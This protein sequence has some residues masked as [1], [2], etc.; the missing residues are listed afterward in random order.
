M[1]LFHLHKWTEHMVLSLTKNKQVEVAHVFNH[2]FLVETDKDSEKSTQFSTQLKAT[3][4]ELGLGGLWQVTQ[5]N[6]TKHMLLGYISKISVAVYDCINCEAHRRCVALYNIQCHSIKHITK[7]VAME[8]RSQADEET[9]SSTVTKLREHPNNHNHF[10]RR[11]HPHP[12]T[13]LGR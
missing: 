2:F 10:V 1:T 3:F 13:Q 5:Q 11:H 9:G 12:D 8:G 7:H 6:Y 4:T